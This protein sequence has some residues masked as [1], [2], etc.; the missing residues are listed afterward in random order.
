MKVRNLWRVRNLREN[1]KRKFCEALITSKLCNTPIPLHFL[2][3]NA[4]RAMQRVQNLEF[5]YIINVKRIDIKADLQSLNVG[6]YERLLKTWDKLRIT[7]RREWEG[8]LTYQARP[9]RHWLFNFLIVLGGHPQL[10]YK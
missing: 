3:I 7:L 9:K 2:G 4:M 1:N 6:L 5:Q 10:I 8:G